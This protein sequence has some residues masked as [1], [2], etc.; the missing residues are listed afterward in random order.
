MSKTSTSTYMPR[1]LVLDD[2]SAMAQIV[3]DHIS[4]Q[5]MEAS[6]VST[7]AAMKQ[8]LRIQQPDILLL[9]LMLYSMRTD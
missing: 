3:I 5:S 8:Q 7:S 9:D 4:T 6:A 1:V 2:D